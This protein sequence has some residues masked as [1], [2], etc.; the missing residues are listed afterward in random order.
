VEE[1]LENT[2][3]KLGFISACNYGK[4]IVNIGTL[5]KIGW[6]RASRTDKRV[7]AIMN[8]VSLK[9]HK[10]PDIDEEK[11][12]QMLNEHLPKDIKIFRIIEMS[13]SF[14][15]KDNN[16]NREY[17]YILPS[18]CL[19]PRNLSK[20]YEGVSIDTYTGNYSYK[21]SPEYHEKL[22]AICKQFKGTRNF[23]NYTKKLLFKDPSARR[24]MIEVSCNE[25]ISYGPFEA[26]KFKLIGQSFLYNQIRK[27][28]GAIIEVCR[29]LKDID[30]FEN[31]FMANKF[32]VPKAPAEGLY[33]YRVI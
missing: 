5:Q 29:D 9:L 18:F 25:L 12:K 21:I 32:D 10:L 26:I 6:T 19:E 16:N 13:R 17:H 3:F 33:L 28:I 24:H 2:L 7:S 8:V 11:T 27:M 22:Q 14:D 1:E 20:S 31:S 15:A 4:K 30:Y 23:H